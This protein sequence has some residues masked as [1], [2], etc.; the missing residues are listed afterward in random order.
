MSN[1][2]F[3]REV[4]EELRQE[5]AQAIWSRFGKLIIALVVLGVLGTIGY[6][7]WDRSV[8]ARAAADGARYIEA[9]ELAEGGD[10]AAALAAFEA[11][12]A[13]GVGAY[14]ELAR[15]QMAAAQDMAGERAAAVET[16]DAVAGSSAPRPLRDL[17]A[18]RAAYILVDTGT[19]QDV[20]ARVERLTNE[21]EPLRYPAREALGLSLWRAGETEEARGFFQSLADD[22]GAPQG[23]AERARL[24]L[25]LIDAGSA[26]AQAPATPAEPSPETQAPAPEAPAIE[27]PQ[28]PQDAAPDAAPEDGALPPS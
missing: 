9:V 21:A 11:L 24:M 20:R 5:R 13:D 16:F 14:P 6:V 8:S 2:T 17:A 28:A 15:L 23:I 12:A 3:I 1:D 22:L 27:A 18:I 7:V 10:T 4:N 26:Q 19:P 25:E